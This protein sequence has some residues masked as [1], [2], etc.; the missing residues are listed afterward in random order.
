[1]LAQPFAQAYTCAS[2]KSH[3]KRNAMKTRSI[4]LTLVLC[5]IGL[6]VS[7]AADNP[8]MGTW[9]LNEA[10][11]KIAAGGFKNDTVVYAADGDNVKVTTAHA[12]RQAHTYRVDG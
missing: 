11:S 6:G 12:R 10:K 7:F 4:I 2:T 5:L 1:M 8:Q 3:L 9:K